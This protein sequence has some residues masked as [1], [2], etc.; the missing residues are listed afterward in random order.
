MFGNEL[1]KSHF[2]QKHI[3]TA[4]SFLASNLRFH[5]SET[6]KRFFIK[7]IVFIMCIKFEY[8]SLLNDLF[9]FYLKKKKT[10]KKSAHKKHFNNK[11]K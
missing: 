9:K 6:S 3:K 7:F 4:L 5:W 8:L 2:S 10:K 11:F 1:R